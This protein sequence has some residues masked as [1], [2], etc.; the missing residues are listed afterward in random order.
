[1][2]C[3]ELLL[4]AFC[5][6]VMDRKEMN[7]TNS[8]AESVV[9][10]LREL[11]GLECYQRAATVAEQFVEKSQVSAHRAIATHGTMALTSSVA[12][13][14]NRGGLVKDD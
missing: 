6:V 8:E 10:M 3:F 14:I 13:R 11:L 4:R 9:S 7:K 12:G 2:A 1:V 5:D